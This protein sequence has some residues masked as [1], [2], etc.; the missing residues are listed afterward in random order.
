MDLFS[1]SSDASLSWLVSSGR[2]C[3]IMTS[4]ERASDSDMLAWNRMDPYVGCE[5]AVAHDL[6]TMS[7]SVQDEEGHATTHVKRLLSSS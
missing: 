6:A 3:S 1:P 7:L 5:R 4:L 2:R